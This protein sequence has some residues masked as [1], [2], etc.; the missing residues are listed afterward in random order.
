MLL[1]GPIEHETFDGGLIDDEIQSTRTCGCRERINH[2]EFPQTDLRVGQEQLVGAG[3]IARV[4]P[5]N[6]EK[7]CD[8]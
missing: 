8:E 1:E 3:K 6:R 7:R 5:L 2:F 4:G